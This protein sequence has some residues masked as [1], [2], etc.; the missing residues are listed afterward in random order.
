MK[1]MKAGPTAREN[2]RMTAILS[3]SELFMRCMLQ[4]WQDLMCRMSL[5]N[6]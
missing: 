1:A 2:V 6:V 5:R 4:S 3:L